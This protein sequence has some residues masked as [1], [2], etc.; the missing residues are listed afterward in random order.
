MLWHGWGS[1]GLEKLCLELDTFSKLVINWSLFFLISNLLHLTLL[2]WQC[3]CE[4]DV[5]TLFLMPV[6]D[7]TMTNME[8]DDASEKILLSL[9]RWAAL[10]SLSLWFVLWKE[11]QLEKLS[12]N[13]KH[14]ENSLSRELKDEKILLRW[15][16]D[17]YLHPQQNSWF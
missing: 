6:S 12:T 13:L 1:C 3:T 17:D 11:K 15:L 2:G 9:Q 8:S 16:F 4:I 10:L 14:K 7:I 5:A